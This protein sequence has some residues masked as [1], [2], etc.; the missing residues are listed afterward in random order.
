M[1]NSL[2]RWS[3]ELVEKRLLI[4]V[5]GGFAATVVTCWVTELAD[6]PFSLQ[7]VCIDTFIIMLVGAFTVHWTRKLLQ[8][9]RHLEGRMVICPACKH[10]KVD[11][12]WVTIEQVMGRST[13][14]TLADRVCPDCA[15]MLSSPYRL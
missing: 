11:E 14:V 9:I 6:P 4:L 15:K 2:V 13:D 10:V 8:R 7:Q 5:T 3:K 12:E 1:H